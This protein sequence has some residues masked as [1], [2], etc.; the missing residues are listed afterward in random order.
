LLRLQGKHIKLRA[1]EPED[2]DLLERWEN[3]TENWQYSQQQ[4]PFSRHILKAYLAQAHQDIYEAKQLRLVIERD[5]RA[6]GLV[7]LYDF[8]FN[9]RRAGIGILIGAVEDRRQGNAQ[10]ALQILIDYAQ[11]A[12]DLKQLYASIGANNMA[13]LKLFKATG[14]KEIG[15]RAQWFRQEKNWEDEHLLQLIF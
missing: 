10:E 11:K 15:V 14:F 13:S 3:T 2:L 9:N 7:D 5:G 1:L 6:I 4:V 12:F 8:D